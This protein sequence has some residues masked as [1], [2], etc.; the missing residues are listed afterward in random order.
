[1]VPVPKADAAPS[2]LS[3]L[4]TDTAAPKG[5]LPSFGDLLQQ[6][7]KMYKQ[8]IDDLSKKN[9]QYEEDLKKWS[10]WFSWA[11]GELKASK[12][13]T[14][15]LASRSAQLEQAAVAMQKELE[16]GRGSQG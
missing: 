9:T 16:A 1:M 10:D 15:A 12:E 6:Y 8:R 14:N 5:A 13:T 2:P 3:P 4:I 7:E 11:S